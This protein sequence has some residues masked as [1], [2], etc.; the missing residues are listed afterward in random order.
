M[1]RYCVECSKYNFRGF[2][3]QENFLFFPRKST[4]AT[5]F[6]T[7]HCFIYY[8]SIFFIIVNFDRLHEVT[9]TDPCELQHFQTIP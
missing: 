6:E 1:M 9:K 5:H 8:T 7:K 2:S 3:L 4:A